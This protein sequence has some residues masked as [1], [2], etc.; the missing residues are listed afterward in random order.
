MSDED[1]N[2]TVVASPR[3]VTGCAFAASGRM[4]ESVSKLVLPRVH[5]ELQSFDEVPECTM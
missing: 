2:D 5:T 3:C 4:G 1:R